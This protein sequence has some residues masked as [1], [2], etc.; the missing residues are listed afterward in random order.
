MLLEKFVS[1]PESRSKLCKGPLACFM[2]GFCFW[3]QN[4][5]FSHSCIY[6]HLLNLSHFNDHLAE[7]NPSS[8]A[9]I[10]ALDVDSFF[11]HYFL[12]CKDRNIL[13]VHLKEIHFS[14]NRFII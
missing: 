11:K 9:V 5:G 14:I 1:C 3:L 2:N 8:L 10:N 12:P 6:R 13:P 4:L 7:N